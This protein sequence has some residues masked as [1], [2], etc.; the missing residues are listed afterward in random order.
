MTLRLLAM[1]YDRGQTCYVLQQRNKF[2]SCALQDRT[3][4]FPVFRGTRNTELIDLVRTAEELSQD[5]SYSFSTNVYRQKKPM[6]N[7]KKKKTD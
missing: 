6:C 7:V 3:A 1:I 5:K 2:K 4:L